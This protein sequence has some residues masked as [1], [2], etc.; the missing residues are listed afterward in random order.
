MDVVCAV[1]VCAPPIPHGRWKT[2]TF[3]AGLRLTGIAAPFVLD[4]PIN[5]DAFQAYV[6]R[7]L[8]PEL[9]PGD[10]V[11]MD[12]LGSHKGMAVQA[13]IEAA[14]ARLLFLPPYSSDF[15]PCMDGSC[16]SRISI[17]LGELVGCGHVYGV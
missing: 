7:V 14:G 1:S 15:N 17:G 10:I 8:V 13:A 4:G 6:E 3:V 2:T 16:G 5:R 12:N 9:N 11:V